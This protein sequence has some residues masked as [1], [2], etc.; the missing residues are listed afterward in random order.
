MRRNRHCQ[1]YWQTLYPEKYVMRSTVLQVRGYKWQLL[2]GVKLRVCSAVLTWTGKSA[3]N[4]VA[5]QTADRSCW[6]SSDSGHK[7]SVRAISIL[8]I[9]YAEKNWS[10]GLKADL[11]YREVL[12]LAK[13]RKKSFFILLSARK[14]YESNELLSTFF[15]FVSRTSFS[16]APGAIKSWASFNFTCIFRCRSQ[17]SGSRMLFCVVSCLFEV[18]INVFLQ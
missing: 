16:F 10:L 12:G 18:F 17:L 15:G 9:K 2:L 7:Y 14:A 11:D 6:C 5:V 1:I 4:A 13:L 3:T 8:H